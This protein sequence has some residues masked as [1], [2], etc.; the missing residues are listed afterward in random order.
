[1]LRELVFKL[2]GTLEA[3]TSPQPL[4]EDP[5]P[6][7]IDEDEPEADPNEALSEMVVKAAP[8]VADFIAAMMNRGR[9]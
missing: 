6:T 3:L 4:P 2:A 5:P 8:V 1:M 9:R 7:T